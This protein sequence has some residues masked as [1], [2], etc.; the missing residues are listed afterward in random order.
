MKFNVI[1][2]ANASAIFMAFV[3]LVCG[4]G[5]LIMPGFSRTLAQSWFHGL[6]LSQVW[7]GSAFS[8][9]F[10]L[11]LVSA[12]ILTWLAGWVFAWTYN[13]FAGK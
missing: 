1:A 9:N 6:D 13:L 12:A 7:S 2:F 4:L 3:Y 10:L 11:G 8:G 5:V